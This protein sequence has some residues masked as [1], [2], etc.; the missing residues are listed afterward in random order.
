M[1]IMNIY[2]KVKSGANRKISNLNIFKKLILTFVIIIIIPFFISFYISQKTA[3]DMIIEQ[4]SSDTMSSIELVTNSIDSLLKKMTS[5]ALYVNEDGNV[6]ELIEQETED[7]GETSGLSQVNKNLRKLD[8]I[9][10]FNSIISNIA[11]NM[12]GTKCNIT[13]ITPAGQKYTNWSTEGESSNTYLDK[14]LLNKMMDKENS[15]IWKGIEKNYVDSEVNSYP[16]VMT[17]VKN[18]FD[19]SG[20]NQYGTFLISISEDEISKLMAPEDQLQK[21][22]I[23]DEN[24]KV[25]SSTKKDWLNKS[26]KSIY[27]CEFPVDEKGYFTYDDVNGEKSIISY[28]RIRNWKV[29]DIK[30]Y[31]SI[32]KQLIDTRNRLLIVNAIFI[33]V[34]MGI[35]AFIAQN[36]SKPLRRLTKMM[37]KT[38]LES[39]SSEKGNA[40]RDEVGLLEGSFNIMRKNIKMLMQDN[41][42]K[43]KKKR[44]AE[45]KSLQAQ[46]S[47]HF[48]FNTLN[49]VRW[50]AINN[51]TKKAADM[52]LALSNLLRMTVVK[53]NEFI[54]VEEEIENLKNYAAIF[55]MRH[56]VEFQLSCYIEDDIK[57]YKIP[58]L[59]LQ[60]LVEN[61]IIHGFE[62][63]LS[64]GIIE[65]TSCKREG[66][67]ILCVKD[68]G[69]GMDMNS[70]PKEKDVKELKFSGIGISNVDERIKLY[71]GEKYGLKI[72]SGTGEGTAVEVQ[73][74][75]QS[76]SEG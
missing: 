6:K 5:I 69:N 33:L 56:S 15:L 24:M 1:N 3:S 55:Q 22:V 50:A 62:G 68:N 73:L 49:A 19:S 43:E 76:G 39:S 26:F 52:V 72:E 63:V 23:L 60:P 29:V 2:K 59:L 46:I 41:L 40:R 12:M 31:D 9:N 58:K 75:E 34:F 54:T 67:V 71:F 35:S 57:Q 30:S 14:Y 53:G 18:I 51:N 37:L 38:D 10:K 64:G 44:D 25:I 17:L 28:N 8:R 20:N 42:D 70:V 21:R 32:T 16:Y 47:P 27:D 66:F 7:S 13:I 4:V 74:P 48:L 36:I 11:F 65:I 45:L 61:A